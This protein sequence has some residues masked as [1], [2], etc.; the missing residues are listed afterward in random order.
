MPEILDEDFTQMKTVSQDARGRV[1]VGKAGEARQYS[2]SRNRHGQIL[3]TPVVQ[4]PEYEVWLWRNPE[5]LASIRRGLDDE[6]AGRVHDL[7]S[8]APYADLETDD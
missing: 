5:A 1:T 7:G 2:V 8:F 4:I 6:A 3:L